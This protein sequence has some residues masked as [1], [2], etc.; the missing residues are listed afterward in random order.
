V[1]I[2]TCGVFHKRSTFDLRCPHHRLIHGRRTRTHDQSRT[3]ETTEG[4]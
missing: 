2:Q 4:Y 1:T 3:R